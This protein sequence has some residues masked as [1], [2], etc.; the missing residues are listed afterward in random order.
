MGR[1]SHNFSF[2]IWLVT[3]PAT[4]PVEFQLMKIVTNNESTYEID[5]HQLFFDKNKNQFRITRSGDEIKYYFLDGDRL[6]PTS[7]YK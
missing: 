4:A 2:I 7:L 1:G 6:V 5:A 3:K